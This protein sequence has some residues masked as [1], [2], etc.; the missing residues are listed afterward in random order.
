MELLNKLEN[1]DKII[2][3]KNNNTILVNII[4]ATI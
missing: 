4:A 1:N 3:N 2:L